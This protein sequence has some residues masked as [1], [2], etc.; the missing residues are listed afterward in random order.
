[1]KSFFRDAKSKM[2]QPLCDF[3]Y[4]ES[5]HSL[6]ELLYLPMPT[7]P[8]A[9]QKSESVLM[10]ST[11]TGLNQ[12]EETILPTTSKWMD[13]EERK[14]FEEILDLR[15]YVPLVVLSDKG[16]PRT[17]SLEPV[18]PVPLSKESEDAVLR[19]LERE[20]ESLK[21]HETEAIPN[22]TTEK[23]DDEDE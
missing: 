20:I 21:L 7:L 3:R 9:S 19:E 12:E 14:H 10:L 1:M 15:D 4:L 8:T 11:G 18:K 6:S 16:V 17:P 22:G 5:I 23:D 2:I 13:E